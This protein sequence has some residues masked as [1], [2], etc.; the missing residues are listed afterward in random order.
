MEEIEVVII[1]SQTTIE[2]IK[3]TNSDLEGKYMELKK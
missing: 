2:V 1:S 3:H